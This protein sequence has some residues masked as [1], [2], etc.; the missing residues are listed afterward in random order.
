MKKRFVAVLAASGL[1]IS[2]VGF[3]LIANLNLDEVLGRYPGAVRVARERI[4]FDSLDEGAIRRQADYQTGDELMAVKRWYVARFGIA[5]AS[6]MNP[7]PTS[8]CVWLT[9][10][11]LALRVVHT[12][13]VLVCAVPQ[14]TRVSVNESVYLLLWP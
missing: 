7:D 2:L 8:H 12:V 6:D 1:A 4:D 3:G 5:P 10:S 11:K 13:S 14:G 9:Q